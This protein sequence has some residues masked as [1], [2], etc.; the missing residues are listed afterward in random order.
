M[1]AQPRAHVGARSTW[2]QVGLAACFALC[3]VLP[4]FLP[5]AYARV[6]SPLLVRRPGAG[7]QGVWIARQVALHSVGY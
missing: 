4:T 6:R 5:Q 2:V 7:G 3:L 1:W